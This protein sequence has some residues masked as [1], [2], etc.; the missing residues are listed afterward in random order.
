MTVS[1]GV[2]ADECPRRVTRVIFGQ[3]PDVRLPLISDMKAACGDVGEAPMGGIFNRSPTCTG[4]ISR[5]D[6]VE[7]AIDSRRAPCL[8][9]TRWLTIERSASTGSLPLW[10]IRR[11][12]RW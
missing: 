2:G 5:H 7:R 6:G 4:N 10:P 3:L 1:A 8:N 11:G 9:L 12:G